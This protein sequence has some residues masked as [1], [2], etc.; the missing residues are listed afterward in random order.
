MMTPH[1]PRRGVVSGLDVAAALRAPE[2]ARPPLRPMAA[3]ENPGIDARVREDL[4]EGE[5]RAAEQMRAQAKLPTIRKP[6]KAW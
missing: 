6:K 1:G 5:R 4:R 3:G 2:P